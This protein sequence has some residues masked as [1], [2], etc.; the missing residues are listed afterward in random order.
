MKGSW[1]ILVTL[2]G[3]QSVKVVVPSVMYTTYQKTFPLHGGTLH[4]PVCHFS[5]ASKL[6]PVYM[7]L[8]LARMP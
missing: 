5:T 2:N 7:P 3:D 1:S 8:P 4:R 6:S